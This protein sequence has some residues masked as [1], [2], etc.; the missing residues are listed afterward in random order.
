M[1]FWRSA[2]QT[3]I[4][5]K[6]W[7]GK[8]CFNLHTQVHNQL[9]NGLNPSKNKNQ[10]AFTFILNCL[11]RYVIFADFSDSTRQ[12]LPRYRAVQKFVNFQ[13]CQ[14]LPHGGNCQPWTVQTF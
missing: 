4:V 2:E 8:K 13:D 11:D 6:N 5:S 7:F 14:Q 3:I 12:L 9:L 1:S 10:N